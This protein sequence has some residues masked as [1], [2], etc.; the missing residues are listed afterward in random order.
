VNEEK[1]W[2]ERLF[3]VL[4]TLLYMGMIALGILLFLYASS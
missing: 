1:T 4:A 3:T 2:G